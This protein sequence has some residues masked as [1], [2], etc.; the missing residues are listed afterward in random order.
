MRINFFILSSLVLLGPFSARSNAKS[1]KFACPKE[2]TVHT[3]VKGHSKDWHHW[4]LANTGKNNVK[5][6]SSIEF[7]QGHPAKGMKLALENSDNKSGSSQWKFIQTDEKQKV[8]TWIA[9]RYN[10]TEVVITRSL[11]MKTQKCKIEPTTDS[12]TAKPIQ[13][14]CE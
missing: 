10:D 9:C 12:G 8:P 3:T 2:I 7:Y 1:Q 11:A 4:N 14:L 13:A 5:K 6:F